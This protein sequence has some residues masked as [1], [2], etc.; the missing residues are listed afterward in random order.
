M[1]ARYRQMALHGC[2]NYVERLKKL[3]MSDPA[4]LNAL[5]REVEIWA[6]RILVFD[7]A[8]LRVYRIHAIK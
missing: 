1:T 6:R 8:G 7:R 5:V 2:S 4:M 3:G